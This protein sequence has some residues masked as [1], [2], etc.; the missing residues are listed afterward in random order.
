MSWRSVLTKLG[1]IPVG[2]ILV[3]LSLV[4]DTHNAIFDAVWTV[5]ENIFTLNLITG[6]SMQVRNSVRAQEC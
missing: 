1:W 4:D 2:K 5:N 6:S 3:S